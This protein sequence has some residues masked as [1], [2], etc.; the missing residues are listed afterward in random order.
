MKM[1]SAA[2]KTSEEIKSTSA[3]KESGG[4]S[5]FVVAGSK[6]ANSFGRSTSTGVAVVGGQSRAAKNGENCRPKRQ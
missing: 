6:S 3:L 2:S 4:K 1:M 5:N